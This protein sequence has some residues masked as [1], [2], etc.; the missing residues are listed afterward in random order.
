M[1]GCKWVFKIKKHANGTIARH[2][3]RLVAKGFS[4]EPEIDYTKTFSHVVKP[5]IVRT[6]L[7]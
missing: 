2:K 1:V 6:V 7:A 4:Q 3:A 5:T